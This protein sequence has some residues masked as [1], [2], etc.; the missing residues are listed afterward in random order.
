MNQPVTLGGKAPKAALFRQRNWPR[1]RL[2]AAVNSSARIF[3]FVVL[4]DQTLSHSAS[5]RCFEKF[6]A[7]H[8]NKNDGIGNADNEDSLNNFLSGDMTD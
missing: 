7:R 6:S 8:L 4:D 1:D 3:Y 5:C 2:F